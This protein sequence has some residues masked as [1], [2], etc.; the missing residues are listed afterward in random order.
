MVISP[1]LSIIALNVNGLNSLIKRHRVA[2]WIKKQDPTICCLPET[3]FSFKDIHR[4]KGVEMK[5]IFDA[6]ENQKHRVTILVSDKIDFKPTTSIREKEDHYIMIKRS[7]QQEE[8]TFINIYA[9]NRE[10]PEYI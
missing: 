4:I 6:N 9:S 3:H 2:L 5:K 1:H 7:I 10:T 8:I